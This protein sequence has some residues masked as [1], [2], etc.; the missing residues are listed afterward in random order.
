MAYFEWPG[1]AGQVSQQ[2]IIHLC[3]VE[4]IDT[5]TGGGHRGGFHCMIYSTVWTV[6]QN[7]K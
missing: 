6:I 4:V 3:I 1:Y 7:S 5:Y 2:P